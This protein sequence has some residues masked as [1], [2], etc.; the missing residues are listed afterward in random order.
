MAH[1]K[2]HAPDHLSSHPPTKRPFLSLTP[3]S[4]RSCNCPQHTE[5]LVLQTPPMRFSGRIV[6]NPRCTFTAVLAEPASMR[7]FHLG[8][9]AALHARLSSHQYLG[10]KVH[11]WHGPHSPMALRTRIM[12]TRRSFTI[13]QSSRARRDVLATCAWAALPSGFTGPLPGPTS[14]YPMRAPT[15]LTG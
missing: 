6:Q 15:T 11:V 5:M 10:K 3:P 4:S 13:D 2:K 12:A 1:V 8:Q 14:A 9:A 7:E